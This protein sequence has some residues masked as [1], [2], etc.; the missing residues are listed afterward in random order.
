MGEVRNL[1]IS[2]LI[3][4]GVITGVSIFV[5]DLFSNY[6]VSSDDMS[7]LSRM[8]SMASFQKNITSAIGNAPEGGSNNIFLEVATG[9]FGATTSILTIPFIIGGLVSDMTTAVSGGIIPGWFGTMIV[10]IISAIIGLKI[11]SLV[12]KVDI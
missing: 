7:S 1:I 11:L 12:M 10:A 8:Q 9:I 5:G 2:V 6:N 4:S 3:F